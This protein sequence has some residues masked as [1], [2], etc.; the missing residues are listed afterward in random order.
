[1][2]HAVRGC[3]SVRMWVLDW[4]E[5][6]G[7]GYTFQFAGRSPRSGTRACEN[8]DGA[9]TVHLR[10]RLLLRGRVVTAVMASFAVL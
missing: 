4:G 9:L 10:D 6:G 3:N 1:M 5:E 8:G 2:V 7:A